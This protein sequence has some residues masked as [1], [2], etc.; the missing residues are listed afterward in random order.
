MIDWFNVRQMFTKTK[1]TSLFSALATADQD[2]TALENDLLTS[3]QQFVNEVLWTNSSGTV[4]DLLTSQRF[5]VNKRLAT[6]F[7][8]LGFPS[9]APTS[10]T[11]FVKATWPASQ[12]RAGMLTQPASSGR[13]PIRRSRRS[14]SAASSST[15]TSSAR[16]PLGM[17]VDLST[18]QAVNVI[19]CKSPD[20]TMTLSTCDSEVLKS[21]ARMTYQPCKACHAQMDLYSRVLLNFGP[22][23][24]YRTVDEAGR[25][26]DPSVT[27][28]PPSPLA[29]Q[30][31]TG[32]AGVRA[33]A[34]VERRDSRLRGPEDRQ[35]R[36]RRHDPDL[37]HLRAQRSR[38][39]TNGT[40]TSL[41]KTVAM[42]NFLRART[43]GTK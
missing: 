24:N 33:G 34:R 23:G 31:V 18:P 17:P 42:A 39:Q 8:G 14:S 36:D 21:D 38:S 5:W 41:F 11:T 9:G 35:L 6:L 20:G 19:N 2:Q 12:G 27:F 32:A 28:A 25:A 10:N 15:T 3:T 7:P 37:Q 29:P 43:G 4:D 16:T 26:I 1:D 13:R 30:M 22:I 40:I